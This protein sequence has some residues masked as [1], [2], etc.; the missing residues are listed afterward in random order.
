MAERA[1]KVKPV[2]L[3]SIASNQAR[4]LSVV[5]SHDLSNDV[6]WIWEGLGH[7]ARVNQSAVDFDL[8]RS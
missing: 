5:S 4:L 1:L 3:F 2:D 8:E 6:I 7:Q